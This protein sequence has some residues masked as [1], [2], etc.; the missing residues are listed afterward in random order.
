MVGWGYECEVMAPALI[1]RKAGD[2][3]KT[4]RRDALSLARLYRAG[5][6]TSVW[7]PDQE[8]ETIRDLVRC[9]E[10]GKQQQRTSMA[11]SSVLS[12]RR[13]RLGRDAARGCLPKR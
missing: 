7:V 13:R 9:R 1:P 12:G 2:R 11:S 3:I 5:E 10:D 4:D 6:L 8:Q